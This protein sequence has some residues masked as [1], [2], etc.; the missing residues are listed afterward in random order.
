ML[1]CSNHLDTGDLG[2][3]RSFTS[4]TS[5]ILLECSV[6]HQNMSTLRQQD[7]VTLVYYCLSLIII[8][9]FIFQV[10]SSKQM[11]HQRPVLLFPS[12]IPLPIWKHRCKQSSLFWFHA[13]IFVKE[14]IT[15]WSIIIV[16]KENKTKK[17]NNKKTWKLSGSSI[18]CSNALAM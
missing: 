11:T 16:C 1:G 3:T 18:V 7:T 15:C 6:N 10:Q 14:M 2:R 9:I 5:P 4:A 17:N 13:L 12:L 8:E